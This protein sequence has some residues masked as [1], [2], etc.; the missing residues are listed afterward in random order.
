MGASAASLSSAAAAKP[1]YVLCSWPP[2]L[3]LYPQLPLL[4][5]SMFDALGR[6]CC[7][8]IRNVSIPSD[9]WDSND[10]YT[11][12][13]IYRSSESRTICPSR[14]LAIAILPV[15]PVLVWSR[16]L[17]AAASKSQWLSGQAD[18]LRRQSYARDSDVTFKHGAV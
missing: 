14:A 3:H 15:T 18:R 16:A 12:E 1:Y 13:C 5:H 4:N 7:I 8:F 2:P 9:D 6:L 10:R 11:H 17:P